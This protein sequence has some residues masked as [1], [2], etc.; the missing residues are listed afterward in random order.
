MV[1]LIVFD[2]ES[3]DDRIQKRR[4]INSDVVTTKIISD[5]K[6]K[7]IGSGAHGIA[8]KQGLLRATIAVRRSICDLLALLFQGKQSNSN[9]GGWTTFRRIKDVCA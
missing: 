8:V 6:L 3:N 2:R 7:F 9:T 1:V 5:V 4:I